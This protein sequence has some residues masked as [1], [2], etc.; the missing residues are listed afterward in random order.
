MLVFVGVVGRFWV[1]V[2]GFSE[3]PAS[4]FSHQF[5]DDLILIVAKRFGVDL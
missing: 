4:G 3:V 1:F 2:W 5:A